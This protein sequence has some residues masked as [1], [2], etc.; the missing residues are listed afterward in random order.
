V[1]WVNR[2]STHRFDNFHT[3]VGEVVAVS[4]KHLPVGLNALP[5]IRQFS[6]DAAICAFAVLQK[7]IDYLLER[8]TLS[9][10]R[11]GPLQ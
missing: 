3:I 11:S 9:V 4:V 1:G 10:A 2:V 6:K 8:Q 7:L 5:A